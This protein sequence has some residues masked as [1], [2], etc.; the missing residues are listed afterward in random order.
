MAS[1]ELAERAG[2]VAGLLRTM[3]NASRLQ[4]LCL[5]AQHGE[6]SVGALADGVG[7]GQSALSQH[8]ARLRTEGIVATRREAQTIHYRIAEPRVEPL[9]MTLYT[10]FCADADPAPDGR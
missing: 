3:A 10:L 9:M 4:I 6:L 1:S 2:F 7:L 8:L 5:L